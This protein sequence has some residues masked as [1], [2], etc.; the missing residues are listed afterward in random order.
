LN[1]DEPTPTPVGA[2]EQAEKAA[3]PAVLERTARLAART[4]RAASAAVWV[5]GGAASGWAFGPDGPGLVGLCRGAAGVGPGGDAGAADTLVAPM[6]GADGRVLGAV[7]VSDAGG[8]GWSA[9]D[10]EALRDLAAMAAAQAESARHCREAHSEVDA[11][12]GAAPFGVAFLDRRMHFVRVNRVLAAVHGKSPEEHIGR[13]LREVLGDDAAPFEPHLARVLEQGD[14]V[15]ETEFRAGPRDGAGERGYYSATFYPAADDAGGVLGVGV[16]LAELTEARKAQ[17]ELTRAKEAAE[18][19]G[20]RTVRILESIT[21]AF[22]VLDR[23]W[24]FEY[25]NHQAERL[26][27][28]PRAGLTG[29][30]IWGEFPEAIGS[31]FERHY[32]EAV[33]SRQA[34]SFEAYFAPLSA[35]FEVRGYPSDEGLTVYFR[36]VT[37]RKTAEQVVRQS[38]ERFRS[39]VKATSAIVWTAAASGEIRD[40]Q[41]D[42]MAFTGQAFH[43]TLGQGW[44]D[45]V[46]P[47]DRATTVLA[48]SH[49]VQTRTPYGVEHRLRR[50]DGEYRHMEARGVPI[51]VE[52]GEVREWVGVHTDVTDRR[53]ADEAARRAEE[54]FRLLVQNSSDILTMFDAEG[55][56]LYESPSVERVLGRKTE[57]RVGH[58][59]FRDTITHPDDQGAK[60]AFFEAALHRPGA[61]VTGRF[62][63]RHTDGTYRDIEAVAT[64]RIGDPAVAG[65]VAN[66]RDITERQQFEE[67]LRLAL[68]EAEAAGRAKDQFLAVL[69]HEL[70]N[71]LNPVLVGVSAMLADPNTPAS[72]RPTLEVARR[73]VALEARLIDDLL[74]VTH[75][76][77]GKLRL[78]RQT[79]DAHVLAR[80]ALELCREEIVAGGLRLTV[81]LSAPRSH[82]AG[83]PARLQQVFWNLIKNA[84]KFTPAGGSVTVRSRAGGA[85]GTDLV[86]EVVD[87][88]VGIAAEALPRIFN[89]FEQ[90]DASVTKQFGGLGL[91]L[92]ISRSLAD[93]HGGRLTAESAGAGRGATFTLVL[94]TTDAPV[95]APA[96]SRPTP[97]PA[98]PMPPLRIL[99]VEDNPDS[100]RILS[101]LLRGKGHQVTTASCVAAALAAAAAH[102]PF[103]MVISDLGL[104]DGSGLDVMRHVLTSH[105]PVKGIALSGYGREDDIRRAREAGFDSHLTKPIDFPGLEDEIRRVVSD[106]V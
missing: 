50:R 103:D 105:G 79:V 52:G 102:G 41:R 14:P 92:A 90:A 25:V 65:V 101:R 16:L 30:S 20:A 72:V 5:L 78:V 87:T 62:R 2:H 6:L 66:Y 96:G 17:R 47:E 48:W 40:E 88:G 26:L 99:L 43:E 23:G 29:R 32:R 97:S 35:W 95:P 70:R 69:S 9:G 57:E 60:R 82:V 71:P 76:R 73:N 89:A 22:F 37:D 27:R 19:A 3:G 55:T 34:T 49:A 83:D 61:T 77:Q 18:A 1:R 10:A 74:D 94:P 56:I 91:G 7:A 53:R 100:R 93:A 67:A 33:E 38:E 106:M 59:I 46:H 24:R 4:L 68:D 64:N 80:D 104:P 84:A 54:R 44:L 8:R 81:D 63:L 15:F 58:N 51:P 45:A 86:V 13:H 31:D 28:R 36:D 11:M 98:D 39:L 21:D 75:I 12:V 85:A 42:W